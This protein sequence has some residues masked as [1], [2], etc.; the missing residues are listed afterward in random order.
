M[1]QHIWRNCSLYTPDM[2]ELLC[3]TMN[4]NSKH[5]HIHTRFLRGKPLKARG[6]TTSRSHPNL[7]PL[8]QMWDTQV[9]LQTT[10][11]TLIKKI[12]C[13]KSRDETISP[14]D[15]E[16]QLEGDKE[17]GLN[18]TSLGRGLPLLNAR[19]SFNLSLPYSL[20]FFSLSSPFSLGDYGG[21]PEIFVHTSGGC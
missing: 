13:S 6:K 19:L 20:G 14:K 5:Q 4:C 3:E 15:D 18:F 12:W 2:S 16:T 17:V 21:Y 8:F 9:F 10:L 11:E 7:L 1:Q